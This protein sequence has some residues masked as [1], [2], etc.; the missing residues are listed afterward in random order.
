MR[1]RIQKTRSIAGL[2]VALAL[3]TGVFV[4]SLHAQESEGKVQRLGAAD[5]HE[6]IV[7][8]DRIFVI[9]TMSP[10]ECLD[11]TIESSICIPCPQ[12]EKLAPVKLPDKEAF[13]IFFCESAGCHRSMHAAQ[14]ALLMG[15]TQVAVL[16]GG[17]P[18]WKEAGFEVAST[19]RIPRRGIQSIKAKGLKK[20][21]DNDAEHLLIV[22]IRSPDLYEEHHIPGAV[23]IGFDELH[24]RY[25]ELP[26]D[27]SVL[28]VDERGYRSFLAACY[29]SW[30]G[31]V[32]IRRLFG[33]MQD[34]DAARL[35]DEDQ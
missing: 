19:K 13:L 28:V 16:D 9:N 15:Y 6:K 32:D 30:K 12:F 5:V 7:S 20:L 33:G 26:M 23:N 3:G 35:G 17:M 25:H 27:K 4:A 11:H 18:S 29:L 1:S 24:E 31:Y 14:K 21:M 34:W 2:I 8:G 10:I 22:D